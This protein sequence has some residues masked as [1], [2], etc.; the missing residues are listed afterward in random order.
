MLGEPVGRRPWRAADGP[1][2]HPGETE[3]MCAAL[4]TDRPEQAA[5]FAYEGLLAMA[6]EIGPPDLSGL[7]EVL[8]EAGG[9]SG[10][11]LDHEDARPTPGSPYGPWPPSPGRHLCGWRCSAGMSRLPGG[12]QSAMT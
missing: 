5:D 9:C 1:Q 10:E 12:A 6:Q 11:Q 3:D 8:T 4:Q 7:T 2:T